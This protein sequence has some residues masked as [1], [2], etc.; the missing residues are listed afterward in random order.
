MSNLP[1]IRSRSPSETTTSTV[2][3]ASVHASNT[4][5][6]PAASPIPSAAKVA[7]TLWNTDPKFTNGR[8]LRPAIRVAPGGPFANQLA[9]GADRVD[10]SADR[11]DIDHGTVEAQREPAEEQ[12]RRQRL[13]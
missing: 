1:N 5:A 13:I 8:A 11:R 2:Q 12:R 9:G 6:R 10:G 3:L 7:A 4:T